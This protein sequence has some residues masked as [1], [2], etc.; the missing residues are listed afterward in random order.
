MA[1]RKARLFDWISHHVNIVP[2]QQSNTLGSSIWRTNSREGSSVIADCS[3][4]WSTFFHALKMP[5]TCPKKIAWNCLKS[6]SKTYLDGAWRWRN[7]VVQ[8]VAFM[9]RD[10]SLLSD[11]LPQTRAWPPPPKKKTLHC[12]KN[13]I[14][15]RRVNALHDVLTYYATSASSFWA[16]C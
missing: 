13:S 3:S 5:S 2:W 9:M 16:A 7:N 11:W 12:T 4:N 10:V 14:F 15:E 6:W 1:T 8:L